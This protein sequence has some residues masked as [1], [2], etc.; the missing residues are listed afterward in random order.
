[1]GRSVGNFEAETQG[2]T[3]AVDKSLKSES[4]LIMTLNFCAPGLLF[5]LD[6]SFTRGIFLIS[7]L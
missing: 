4:V 5:S 2:K 3:L 6:R 7:V 1:M